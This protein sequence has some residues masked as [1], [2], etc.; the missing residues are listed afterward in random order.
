MPVELA[1]DF[2]AL[3]LYDVVLYCDDS[4]SM[5]F[6]VRHLYCTYMQPCMHMHPVLLV[7]YS[8]ALCILDLTPFFQRHARIIAHS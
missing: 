3:A 6:E 1:L 5:A 4:G 7:Y 8:C 2:A